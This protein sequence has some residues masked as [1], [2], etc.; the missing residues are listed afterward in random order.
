MLYTLLATGRIEKVA[1][2]IGF[3]IGASDDVTQALLINGL[4]KGINN[5]IP[6][7]SDLDMQLCYIAEK[8]DEKSERV[9]IGLVEFIKLKNEK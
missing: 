2:T 3:E 4:C 7:R 9:L 8:L 1:D 5:S 6:Q